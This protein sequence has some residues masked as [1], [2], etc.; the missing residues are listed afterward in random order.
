VRYLLNGEAQEQTLTPEHAAELVKKAKK[1]RCQL[2]PT[3]LVRASLSEG[4]NRPCED[5]AVP[6]A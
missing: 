4:S 5:T 3:S 1:R 2:A 6:W